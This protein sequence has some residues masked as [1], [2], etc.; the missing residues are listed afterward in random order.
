MDHK[1][2]CAHVQALEMTS[3]DFSSKFMMSLCL[4]GFFSEFLT[5][6]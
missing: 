4:S 3:G 6:T 2:F 5:S 1:N